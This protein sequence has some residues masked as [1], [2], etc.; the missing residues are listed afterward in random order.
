MKVEVFG[1]QGCSICL[2]AK[3]KLA[4]LVGKW[5]Y[6]EKVDIVFIDMD[7]VD[8]LAEGAFN[9]VSDIPTTIVSDDGNALGRWEGQ[10]PR[11]EEIKR[12][13]SACR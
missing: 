1:K 4:H 6:K 13:L 10:V 12:A 3:R 7:T 2:S 9:D 8:G 11:S 5:G